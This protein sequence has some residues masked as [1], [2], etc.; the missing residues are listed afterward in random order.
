MSDDAE[1]YYKGW[2]SVFQNKP[3]KLLCIW[4]VD[5]AWCQ[6]LNTIDVFTIRA[7]VFSKLCMFRNENCEKKFQE[8]LS[9]IQND[10]QETNVLQKFSE[11]FETY[12]V[13]RCEQWALCFRKGSFIGTNII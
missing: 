5:R 4:H 7:E 8:L 12:Y 11:Y 1:Q 2:V 13:K 3:K 6:K 10:F 9:E